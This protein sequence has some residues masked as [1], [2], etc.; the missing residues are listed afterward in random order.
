MFS[1][2]ASSTSRTSSV[3]GYTAILSIIGSAPSG[4]PPGIATPPPGISGP[5][6]GSHSTLSNRVKIP[7]P[8]NENPALHRENRTNM[9]EVCRT[10]L[11]YTQS[12]SCKS[13]CDILAA[14]QKDDPDAPD[15]NDA[16]RNNS[17]G[18]TGGAGYYR[19]TGS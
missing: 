9:E 5:P 3:A 1:I 17:H 13:I 6:L 15:S 2:V 8:A 4:C 11:S 12:P 18:I 14:S 19:R 16:T 7:I 10:A